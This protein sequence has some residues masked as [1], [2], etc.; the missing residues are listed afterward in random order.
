VL[1]IPEQ[2]RT[3]WDAL[4]LD[5]EESEKKAQEIDTQIPE[6][7]QAQTELDA[8]LLD[9]ELSEKMVQV[10]EQHVSPQLFTM[11]V[12][13]P[14]MAQAGQH[15]QQ[16]TGSLHTPQPATKPEPPRRIKVARR[17]KVQS[18]AKMS[19]QTILPKPS[20][21]QPPVR[22]RTLLPKPAS[23]PLPP[24]MPMIYYQL[25]SSSLNLPHN[26]PQ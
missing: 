17:G 12:H 9:I 10:I 24:I 25:D 6:Q 26:H 16:S 19:P 13:P 2:T 11:I 23:Q 8:V 1:T 15:H 7:Q 3:E 21:Q 20:V 5:I 22:L 14:N 18:A 4:L